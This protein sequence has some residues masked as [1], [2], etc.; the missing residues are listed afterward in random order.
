MFLHIFSLTYQ[1]AASRNILRLLK[2]S[3][4]SCVIGTQTGSTDPGELVLRPPM[5]E[6]GEHKTV[7]RQSKDTMKDM[8]E[9]A[10]EALG[11]E[12]NVW[13]G[14][15]EAE[16]EERAKGRKERGEGWEKQERFF[17]GESERRIFFRVKRV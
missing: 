13:T 15:D 2:E 11:F 3:S 12:V 9:K 10:A 6:P 8:W 4:G 16:A 14:Y 17:V 7:F 1:E 5:C